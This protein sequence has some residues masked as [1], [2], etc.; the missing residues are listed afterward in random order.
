[1]PNPAGPEW[2]ADAVL[3]QIYPQSYA[4]SDGDGIGDFAG[5]TARLEYLA[6]LGV[7]AVWLTPCFDSPFRDAGYDVR[8]YLTTAARYG[9]NEELAKLTDAARRY[10]IRVVL[11]LVAGHTSDQHPWFLASA[12]DPADHRYIWSDRAAEGFVASPGRRAGWYRPNFFDCQPALNYGYARQDPAEPWRQPI[13][14]EGPRA[15]RA[16]LRETMA[17]WLAAGVS[18]FRVDMAS[19]LVKDDP[20]FTETGRLWRE[21]RG[22]LAERHP[23]AILLAEWG[24]PA[25]S[26]PMGFHGDFFLHFGGPGD[27]AA[28][29][30]LWHNGTGTVDETWP[31]AACYF[32]A[33]GAGSME[34]FVA[35]WQRTVDALA[36]APGS[37]HAILPTANHDLSR[38]ACG[39]RT[40]EQLA[41]AFAFQLTWP[42][43]PAVYY[44]DEI[45]MRYVPG[46][47]DKEG[48]VLGPQYNRAGSRTPMQWDSGPNAGFSTAPADRLYLPVD[49]AADRPDVA[50]QRADTGSLLHVVRRLIALRRSHPALGTHGSLEVLHTGYPLVYL[51]GGRFLVVV[52]PRREPARF[53]LEQ[54]HVPRTALIAH[55]VHTDPDGTV[56]AE[57]FSYAVFEL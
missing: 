36:D 15:N 51:R 41:P 2:P 27:G 33:D 53:A 21:M 7:S 32:D 19:S 12:D 13:D 8:D 29:R 43:V 16:A 47:P 1:M 10:G 26:V 22:W 42:S 40:G 46:L 45:G 11:D 57:G 52:N 54:R 55:G 5:L 31:P 35:A 20:G 38:L 17:Q 30:S 18:G 14:A 9:S 4:D 49:P 56:H 39:P 24:D 6:W 23:D 3:Y 44:G 25:V 50:T 37:G 34:T 28:L 48:S